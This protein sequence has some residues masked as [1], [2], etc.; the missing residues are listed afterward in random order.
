LPILVFVGGWGWG[1]EEVRSM[2]ERNWRLRDHLRIFA[3][4][5]DAELIWLYR[6][7]RF[8][9][10]PAFAEGFGLAAAESLSFG[11]PVV[12]SNC[13]ALVEATEGLMPCHDPLDFP[14]WLTEMRRLILDDDYVASLRTQA[15]GFDGVGHADFGVAILDATLAERESIAR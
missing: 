4:T 7:A 14:S 10:C 2:S 13:P 15:A 5:T 3:D 8:T 9:V 12:I 1:A 11:T 6:H